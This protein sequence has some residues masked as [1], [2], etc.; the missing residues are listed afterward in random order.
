MTR[1]QGAAGRRAEV[2]RQLQHLHHLAEVRSQ[3]ADRFRPVPYGG[4][5]RGTS[6][7]LDAFESSTEG[8]PKLKGIKFVAYAD[9]NLRNAAL[10]PGT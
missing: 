10:T 6:I 9:E 8:Y 3:R 4:A 1:N 5:G 7:E 2:V